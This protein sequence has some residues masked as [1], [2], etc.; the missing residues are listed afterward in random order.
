M[1]LNVVSFK[2]SLSNLLVK[3]NTTTSSYDISASMTKRFQTIVA[4]YSKAPIPNIL[5]PAAFVE[6]VRQAEQF[7]T[8]GSGAKRL[9]SIY[10]D[11]VAVTD[12]GIGQYDGRAKSETEMFYAAQNIEALIRAYPKLSQTSL[13]MQTNIESVDYGIVESNDTWNCAAR[14]GLNITVRTL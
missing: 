12:Y 2:N 6:I 10:A 5:Y 4:Q 7:E 8:S 1:A 9:V 13:V 14:I 11:S 3:N